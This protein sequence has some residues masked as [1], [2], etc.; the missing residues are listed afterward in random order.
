MTPLASLYAAIP[1]CG[2]LVALFVVEQLV[3][4]WKNGFADPEAKEIAAMTNGVLIFL[5]AGLFL[6]LGYLGVPVAF[7][8]IA[9]V[10]VVTAFTPVGPA[11]DDD[12]ALQRH[13]RRGAAGGA[14]LP[15]GGRADD[16][17]QRH[18]AHDQTLA[19]ADRPPARRPGAGG[20]GVQH[21][22]RRRVGL[23]GRRC[24]GAGALARPRHEA[25]GLRRGLRRRA[26]RLGLDD[27]QPDPAEH[28][29]GGLRRH[30]QRVDRRAVPRRRGAGGA[31][32]HRADD[33]QPLLRTRSA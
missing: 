33:L 32:G 29:G 21:V 20:H 22:L 5:M 8:L 17:V 26:D 10:L 12:A 6:G 28:H 30:R 13:R 24:R 25:R 18:G 11:V 16:V 3:N 1:L 27:G 23:V 9:G 19:G 15:A 31:G 7:A 4:G 2:A 14:V